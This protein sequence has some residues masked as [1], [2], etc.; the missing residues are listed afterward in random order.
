MPAAA[1]L[2]RVAIN[3]SKSSVI[4]TRQLRDLPVQL[5]GS[6]AALIGLQPG[7]VGNNAGGGNRAGSVT[8]S[9]ADQGNVT[10]DGID[11]NDQAGNFAFATVAN[12]PIDSI[13]E[14]RA[15]TSG[16]NANAG[17]SSGGQTDL[18]TKSGT[19]QFHGSLREYY[20]TEKTAA[21]SFF[22]NRNALS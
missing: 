16:P 19:N 21:N 17:R 5:R 3:S 9:R 18:I 15:V 14:F 4:G 11:V 12:A 20:R 6:P 8:G 13:Q 1:L 10:V 22:N 7:A 2:T